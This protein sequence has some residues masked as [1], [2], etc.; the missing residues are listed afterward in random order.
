MR[1]PSKDMLF[2]CIMNI[3]K[4][5]EAFIYFHGSGKMHIDKLPGGLLGKPKASVKPVAKFSSDP[6]TSD[7]LI[8]DQ[9]DIN[10]D[11]SQTFNSINLMTLERDTRNI[12]FLNTAP[13]AKDDV[14][15][16]KKEILI[17][18]PAYG[19]IEV[20][21][22]HM[23]EMALRIFKP[24]RKTSFKTVGGGSIISPLSFVTVDKIA[25]RLVS[26]SRNYNAET[27]DF[28]TDYEAEWLNG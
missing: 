19:E 4:R 22:T 23:D 5:F 10:I 2:N 12:I 17:D 1:F 18:Q 14:L 25:F 24:I 21:R 20:A 16:F 26:L 27:N 8:L 11:F 6:N 7:Q 28:T 15:R 9:K 3:V 13:T